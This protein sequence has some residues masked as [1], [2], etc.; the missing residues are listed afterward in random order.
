[1]NLPAGY[2]TTVSG[3]AREL[4]RTFRE[5]IVAFLLSIAFMYDPR[6]AV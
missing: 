6:F 1:M 5:F 4:E 2:S 3:R